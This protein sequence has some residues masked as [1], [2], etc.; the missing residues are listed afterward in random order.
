MR[1]QA[2]IVPFPVIQM[3]QLSRAIIMIFEGHS[4]LVSA[5][6]LLSTVHE[7]SLQIGELFSG[8]I[9]EL[10]TRAGEDTSD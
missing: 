10:H 8:S 3:Y 7:R 1:I 4:V 5:Y 9:C 2:H 6:P